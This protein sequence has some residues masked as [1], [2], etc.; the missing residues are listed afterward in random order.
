MA[1]SWLLSS[2]GS[3]SMLVLLSSLLMAELVR[4]KSRV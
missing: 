3:I 1:S 2:L 4:L